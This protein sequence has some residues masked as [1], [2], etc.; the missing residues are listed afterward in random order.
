MLPYLCIYSFQH[1][2]LSSIVCNIHGLKNTQF[3]VKITSMGVFVSS[4][5]WSRCSIKVKKYT[6]TVMD[7]HAF[8]KCICND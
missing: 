2:L 1:K 8:S 5:V 4:V 7:G 6:C 3:G